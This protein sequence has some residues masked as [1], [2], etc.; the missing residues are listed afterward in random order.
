M[1]KDN[2]FTIKELTE[3]LIKE[4]DNFLETLSNVRETG[5]IEKEKQIEI[6]KKINSQDGHIFVVIKEDKIIGTSTILIEQKFIRNGA[7]TGHIE[8]V[9]VDKNLKGMGIGNAVVKEC[10]EYA[11][12][13]GC[14]KIIL[15]CSEEV[16]IFYEKLGFVKS[17]H[18]MR[19]NI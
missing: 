6:L 1:E 10:I 8:D 11:K 4:K 7:K 14:Y 13:R 2:F 12:N 18:H 17:D 19:M 3:E 5:E 9:A 15:D 16:R